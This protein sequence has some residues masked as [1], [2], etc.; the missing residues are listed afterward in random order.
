MQLK[1]ED[2]AKAQ[3]IKTFLEKHYQDHFDYDYI[4]QKFHIAAKRQPADFPARAMLVGPADNFASEADRENLNLHAAPPGHKEM[5]ELVK[6]HH[7][8]DDEQKGR[9]P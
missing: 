4:A 9:K 2:L 5:S 7:N 3:E 8:C 6:E 1:N